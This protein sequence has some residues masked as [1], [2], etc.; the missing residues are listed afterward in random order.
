VTIQTKEIILHGNQRVEVGLKIRFL[1]YVISERPQGVLTY[2]LLLPLQVLYLF[3]LEF[4]DDADFC[5]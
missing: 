4:V 5:G 2:F 3:L 1:R